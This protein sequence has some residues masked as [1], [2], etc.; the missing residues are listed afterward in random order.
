ME[1]PN[2]QSVN[3]STVNHVNMHVDPLGF[4]DAMQPKQ[5]D[6]KALFVPLFKMVS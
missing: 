1:A 3:G 6:I 4:L 5:L 2:C